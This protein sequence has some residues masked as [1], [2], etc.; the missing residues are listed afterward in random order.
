MHPLEPISAASNSGMAKAAD[1]R[2]S[3]RHCGT[4]FQPTGAES[5][6]CCTGCAYV[7]RL[8]HEQ[9]LDR[10]YELKN[11][12]IPPV[13]SSVFQQRDFN[14]LEQ[15]AQEAE[16]A[17]PENPTLL[18]GIQ[19]ISCIGCV[20]LVEKVFEDLPGARK[21][22]INPQLGQL[23]LS[24]DPHHFQ[25]ADF[26]STLQRFGYAVGPANANAE[27]QSGIL[28]G[29]L[30]LSGAFVLNTM[31]FTL[32]RY[33]G[34]EQDFELAPFFELLALFFATL[35][36]L[37]GGSY[38]I[39]RAIEALR[40]KTLHIDLPIAIGIVGAYAGSLWGWVI[41]DERLLYF[42]FVALFIFLMLLG[43]LAQEAALERNRNALLKQQ[44]QSDQVQT[45]SLAGDGS[46]Q[47]G[48]SKSVQDLGADDSFRLGPGAIVPVTATLIEKEALF[49]YEW[50]TGESEPLV[51]ERGQNIPAGA[52][53]LGNS[54]V[55]FIATEAYPQSFLS[56]LREST[57]SEPFR[58]P[59]YERVLRNYIL[60]I[61]ILAA[62][63][64][65]AW[66]LFGP[67][68]ST[69]IQV[70]VSLLVVSCP[71][72]LGVAIPLLH[73]MSVSR[74]QRFGL[75][76][77]SPSLWPRI[78]DI[79]T[80]VFD[81]TGTL[82]YDTPRLMNPEAV[83]ALSSADQGH[84]FAC[85][86]AGLHPYSRAIRQFLLSRDPSLLKSVSTRDGE[87]REI[88]SRGVELHRKDGTFRLGAPQWA[89]PRHPETHSAGCVLTRDGFPLAAFS[90]SEA[91]REDA[92]IELEKLRRSGFRLMIL[93][94][95][96]PERVEQSAQWLGL[97]PEEYAGGLKP[98]EKQRWIRENAPGAALMLGDGANDSPAFEAAR[99]TGTP[100]I[101]RNLLEHRAD[102][103]FLG[104]GIQIIRLLFA[105]AG[106]KRSLQRRVFFFTLCY[107]GVTGSLS[108]A[109]LMNPLLAAIL[110][111]L[112]SIVSLLLVVAPSMP[113]F[114]RP[115]TTV[116]DS[117][118]ERRARAAF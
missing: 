59:L 24:W 30:A 5:E 111:P 52:H 17:Q 72:A 102:F 74:L 92:R 86:D 64:G 100:V 41:G 114:S 94:G 99:C 37:V 2:A 12:A 23:S 82:T 22:R 45:G 43:R 46:F 8:I 50:I 76:I 77:K 108:L 63:G 53:Y 34:M 16:T 44:P 21:I 91:F 49:S 104:R 110:M 98:G 88:V 19:G 96:R 15:A 7:F 103:Y 57:Q 61:L 14:W 116:S 13:Q 62:L 105:I 68:L 35:S 83:D 1:S 51:R 109:A 67:G 80:L 117:K 71:C 79:H 75:Y 113:D 40:V 66:S 36:L 118:P 60:V 6:F 33:L 25:P 112:S 20:W 65:T 4:P 81:K 90:F 18:L 95:D 55:H 56:R 70:A 97:L 106:R 32:P 3:C 84:L 115:P 101:D 69:G 73:E 85:A 42:D 26:A 87:A 38:F 29:K 10:Y 107:N 31:L 47:P 27:R 39:R 93:S 78:R 28:S 89:A 48:P 54:N 58:D 11:R 9:N